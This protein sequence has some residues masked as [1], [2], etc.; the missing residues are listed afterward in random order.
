MSVVVTPD[1]ISNSITALGQTTPSIASLSDGRYIATWISADDTGDNNINARVFNA[2]G[3]PAGTDFLVNNEVANFQQNPT[4]SSLPGGGFVMTWHTVFAD[5][6]F[7]VKARFFNADGTPLGDEILISEISGGIQFNPVVTTLVDGH[8]VMAWESNN[9]GAGFEIKARVFNSDGTVASSEFL[10]NAAST[11]NHKF[12]AISSLADGRMAITWEKR[13]GSVDGSITARIFNADGTAAGDEFTVDSGL[14]S[15]QSKPGITSL[16]D[17]RVMMTWVN[18]DSGNHN[19]FARVFNANGSAAGDEF[20][21]NATATGEQHEPSIVQLADGRIMVAWQTNDGTTGP[22][23]K[24]RIINADGTASGDEFLASSTTA[25]SQ[26]SPALVVLANGKVAV[27]WYSNDNGTD[28]DVRSAWI[29][30]LTFNGTNAADSWSGGNLNDKITG[31]AGDD[32]FHGNA[33]ADTIIGGDGNDVMTG[34][35]GDDQMDA[36]ANNDTLTGGT[37]ND[38]MLGGDGDDNLSGNIGSDRLEGGTGADRLSGGDGVDVI[39]GGMGNDFIF[40]GLGT[41]TLTG[42]SGADQFFYASKQDGTDIINDFRKADHF[43]FQGSEFGGLKAGA[44]KPKMFIQSMKNKAIDGNDHF[45]FRV[46]DD[47]LWYDVDG[48]GGQA[49]IKIADLTNDFNLTAS[50]ILIV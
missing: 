33:G 3:T 11:A 24:A 17:G 29:D 22:D 13:V 21:V 23:I 42:G 19:I 1:T 28:F 41:D 48:K 40:G 35:A 44:L 8:T 9:S 12:P 34:D 25:S 7:D 45:I 37:G 27:T 15:N 26:L 18:G 38:T 31:L 46:T 6:D 36:G 32:V 30:P 10:V 16:S 50:H 2:D 4:V 49:S 47:T 39:L 5:D 14:T 43:V 20:R